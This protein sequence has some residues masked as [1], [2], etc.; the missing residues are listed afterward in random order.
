MP[1]FSTDNTSTSSVS[2]N[3]STS[4]LATAATAPLSTHNATNTSCQQ[5]ELPYVGTRF[6]FAE[7]LNIGCAYNAGME[8][9]S[10]AALYSCSVQYVYTLGAQAK[11]MVSQ[12]DHLNLQSGTRIVVVDPAF[13]ELVVIALSVICQASLEDVQIFVRHVFAES[14]STST[15]SRIRHKHAETA[16]MFN[17]NV[18]LSAIRVGA[19]D[20][21]FFGQT[22]VLTGVDLTSTYIYSLAIAPDRTAETWQLQMMLLHNQGLNLATSISDAGN[23][24]LKGIQS[25]FP[26]CHIQIDV[27]HTLYDMGNV[28][29][30]ITEKVYAYLRDLFEAEWQILH[31]QRVFEKTFEKWSLMN[32]ECEA[33][34]SICDQMEIL[35]QWAKEILAFPGYE[36]QESIVLLN[37]IADEFIRLAALGKDLQYVKFYRLKSAA[38]TLKKRI[39]LSQKYLAQLDSNIKERAKALCLPPEAYHLAYKM[40]RLGYET[41]EYA[42]AYHRIEELLRNRRMTVPSLMADLDDILSYTY[43]ASSMVENV[44]SRL[45]TLLNDMR[46]LTP[47]MAEMIQLYMNT[48]P[49]R[50]SGVAARIGKSPLEMLNGDKSSFMDIMFPDFNPVLTV[51][52]KKLVA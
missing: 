40:R 45:R 25:A 39:P 7:R 2:S 9:K 10:L 29:C 35:D 28:V 5:F 46:G 44:N 22:P 47:D 50:R 3:P 38:E 41:Q 17:T 21:I 51:Q 49:Y 31:G 20:E 11:A 26:E 19:N 23:G 13:I 8:A 32:A 4:S 1:C 52:R 6:S 18:N 33:I 42:S 37:W 24:L 15:I 12:F 43:K 27:F 36:A 14:L 48:K 16:R 30:G 34:I